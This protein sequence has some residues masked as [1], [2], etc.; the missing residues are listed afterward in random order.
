[1]AKKYESKSVSLPDLFSKDLNLTPADDPAKN[2]QA[3]AKRQREL[4]GSFVNWLA[5]YQHAEQ[6]WRK[7]LEFRKG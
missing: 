3:L 4:S 2:L 5:T 7:G 6:V 1:L